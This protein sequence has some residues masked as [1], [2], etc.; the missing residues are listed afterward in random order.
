M[1]EPNGFILGFDPGGV[2][3]FG[4]SIC[5]MVDGILKPCR[6]TGVANDAWHTICDVKKALPNKPTVLAAGIDSPLFWSNKGGREV[7]LNQYQGE[8]RRGMK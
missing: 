3:H 1:P 2:G 6:E 4:W 5:E 8:K 7:D